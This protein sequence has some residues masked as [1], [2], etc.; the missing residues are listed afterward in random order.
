MVKR[1]S[2]ETEGAEG[3]F[4]PPEGGGEVAQESA[5]EKAESGQEY[6]LFTADQ[7][8]N[9]TMLSANNRAIPLTSKA[10]VIQYARTAPAGKYVLLKVVDE[11]EVEAPTQENIVRTNPRQKRAKGAE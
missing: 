1:K 3:L 2:G 8:Y 4:V 10:A 5:A 7:F 9:V 6:Y 11:L